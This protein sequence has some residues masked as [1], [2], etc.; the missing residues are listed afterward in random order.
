MRKV[1]PTPT[2]EL[3]CDVVQLVDDVQ[4][5]YGHWDDLPFNLQAFTVCYDFFVI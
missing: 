2:L 4:V 5:H 1:I 3:V